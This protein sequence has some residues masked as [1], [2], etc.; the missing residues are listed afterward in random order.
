MHDNAKQ[1]ILAMLGA[2][3]AQDRAFRR[4]LLLDPHAAIR[5]VSDASIPADL[6]IKFVEKDPDVDVMIVLPDFVCEDGELSEE[7]I[8]VVAGG[9]D[10]G[11]GDGSTV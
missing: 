7:D 9:T 1:N 8:A 5:D 4:K 11:C 2:R 3:A 6:R 10:W